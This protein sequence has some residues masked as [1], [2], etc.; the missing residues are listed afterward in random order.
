MIVTQRRREKINCPCGSGA[1]RATCCAGRDGASTA[2]GPAP[3]EDWPG[4]AMLRELLDDILEAA[5]VED[6]KLD[7]E[8]VR[9][10]LRAIEVV[11]EVLQEPGSDVPLALSAITPHA[12]PSDPFLINLCCRLLAHSHGDELLEWLHQVLKRPGEAFELELDGHSPRAHAEALVELRLASLPDGDQR[13]AELG[14]FIP[15]DGVEAARRL[16]AYRALSP[17]A[18]ERGRYRMDRP[19]REVVP[20]LDALTRRFAWLLVNHWGWSEGRVVLA[21]LEIERV[22][23]TRFD[24]SSFA[25]DGL[26]AC[27]ECAMEAPARVDLARGATALALD[28]NA[29]IVAWPV[30]MEA[31]GGPFRGAALLEALPLW[32]QFLESLKLIDAKAARV[33]QAMLARSTKMLAPTLLDMRDRALTAAS[34][35]LLR[36]PRAAA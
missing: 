27:R 30:L 36:T 29:L 28:V 8:S 20:F 15:L 7:E 35:R 6:L 13:L 11:D 2:N 17:E 16:A 10:R 9:Q 32:V 19:G 26:H 1:P 5:S 18:L 12:D 23:L 25:I 21:R 4:Q 24:H 33:T 22:L 34:A 3:A 31:V 14:R